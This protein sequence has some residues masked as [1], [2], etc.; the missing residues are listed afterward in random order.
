MPDLDQIKQGEQGCGTDAGRLANGA[1][2]LLPARHCRGRARVAQ[3]GAVD[4]RRVRDVTCLR[5]EPALLG[6]EVD[7]F[8]F[9]HPPSAFRIWNQKNP[10]GPSVRR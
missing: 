6:D 7:Q 8:P 5:A 2:A 9:A 10:L 1:R 4:D 3:H